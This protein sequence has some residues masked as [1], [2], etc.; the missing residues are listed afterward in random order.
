MFRRRS[1]ADLLG[2]VLAASIAAG[3]AGF[4]LSGAT[5]DRGTTHAIGAEN[6][7]I[8]NAEHESC[9]KYG[10]YASIATLR[11]DGFLKKLPA[12]NSVVYLPGPHCGTIIVGS[13]SYQSPAR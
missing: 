13:P 9:K 3:F 12:Y 1:F 7:S 8:V 4:I 2:A 10:H 6:A 11:S 5:T